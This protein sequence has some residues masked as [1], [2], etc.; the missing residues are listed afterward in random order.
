MYKTKERINKFDN[1]RGFA[2]FLIVLGHLPGLLSPAFDHR[3]IYIIHLPIFFFVS[4]YFS[5]IGPDEPLKAFKRLMIPYILFCLIWKLYYI[6]LVGG[7]GGRLFIEPEGALWFLI[8]L[9]SMK[10]ILPIISRFRYPIFYSILGALLIGC[11]NIPGNLLG[12][13]RTFIFLPIF[14]IGFYYNDYKSQLSD[15]NEKFV[16]FLSQNNVKY[17]SMIIIV[18]MCIIVALNVPSRIIFL[19]HPYGNQFLYKMCL[20]FIVIILGILFTITLNS[21]MTNKSCFL[22]K[23]GKNSMAVYILHPYLT[24][25]ILKPFILQNFA[26]GII[27]DVIVLV[28]TFLIVFVLSRDFVSNALNVVFDFIFNIFVGEKNRV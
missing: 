22:T 11:F 19:Q 27:F 8:A 6:Y 23:I 25:Y 14:L 28:F 24:K 17:I 12:I 7:S 4:G 2:I 13:T 15:Y 16:N 18:I 5:K 21:L 3:F 9:F 26:P 20:K 1:L 10:M